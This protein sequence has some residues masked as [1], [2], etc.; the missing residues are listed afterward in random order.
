MTEFAKIA[1]VLNRF[2]CPC[3]TSIHDVGVLED[4]PKSS[5]AASQVVLF[6][7]E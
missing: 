5:T 6:L 1:S 7:C 4:V 2:L 3:A